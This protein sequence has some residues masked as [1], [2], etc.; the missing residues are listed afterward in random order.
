MSE[1][2]SFFILQL[3]HQPF[4]TVRFFNSLYELLRPKADQKNI[5][6]HFSI[7]EKTPEHLTGDSVRLYQVLINLLGNALKFIVE[8]S[9]TLI[10]KPIQTDIDDYKILFEIH[11]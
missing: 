6:L 7:D 1:L 9:V 4:E 11:L 10:V 5:Q 3:N 2:T 8:G